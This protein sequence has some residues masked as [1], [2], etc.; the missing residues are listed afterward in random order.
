MKWAQFDPSKW[1]S[2]I[3]MTGKSLAVNNNNQTQNIT[4]HYDS[5]LTVNGNVDKDALPELQEILEQSYQYT[6]KK[7]TRETRKLGIR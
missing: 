3:D 7:L 5:L 1:Y 6:S 2:E 4:Y